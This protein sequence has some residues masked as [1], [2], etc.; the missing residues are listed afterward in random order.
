[1]AVMAAIP[2]QRSLHELWRAAAG[3]HGVV[4][5]DQLLE[6][7]FTR[8]A[9]RCHERAGRLH[10]MHRRV[11]AVGRPEVERRGVLLAAVLACGPGAILSDE[12]GTE[13]WRMLP[14]FEGR[15]HVTV[16]APRGPRHPGLLVHRRSSPVRGETVVLG[17]IPVTAP[18]RTLVDVA[19][20][21][22]PAVLERAINEAD[23]LNLIDPESLRRE[24]GQMRR[25]PGAL[26]L[27][28]LLDRRTF[29]L[30]DS[31]LERMFLPIV[32]RAHL[33]FPETG[34]WLNG[35]KSDFYWPALGLV[36][37]T[38]GLRYHRTPAQQARD[39]LRDQTHTAA[40]R[41]PLRF[42][43][44]QVRY[45]SSRVEATLSTVAR[46]LRRAR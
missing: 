12:S 33:P 14:R 26:A 37:E 16:S 4:T 44:A 9:I 43:H 42:T 7:G 6:R 46:R 8:S 36:V 38:D 39:R 34:A 32:R 25:R 35:F 24:V 2:A 3:Q 19:A 21:L 30:T 41:T 10:L 11:Y 45:E 29:T 20:R 15:I 22:H 23:R 18:A 13:L 5:A 27:A 17:G 28:T 1:M 31:E 40:G